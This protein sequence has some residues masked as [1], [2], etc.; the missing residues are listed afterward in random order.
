MATKEK[1]I[2]FLIADLAG[3]TAFTEA[4]GDTAAADI[5]KKFLQIIKKTLG[6][7]VELRERIG[8]E[9]LITGTDADEVAKTAVNICRLA[10]QADNFPGMHIGIHKGKVIVSEGQFFGSTLNLTSRIADYSREGQIICSETFKD[11]ISDK[12]AFEFTSLGSVRFKN[13]SVPMS[14]FEMAYQK[15]SANKIFDPVCKMQLSKDNAP[16]KLPYNGTTYYFCSFDCA[17]KFSSN[18]AAF[19]EN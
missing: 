14:L 9:V 10:E 19:L 17:T 11:S 7:G 5:V 6:D 15:S 16:A 18:P 8:D 4:H 1:E 12:Q 2:I 13:Y 3:Y